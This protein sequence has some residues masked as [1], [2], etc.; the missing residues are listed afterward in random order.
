MQT[1]TL[2]GAGAG[3]ATL[4]LGESAPGGRFVFW[5]HLTSLLTTSGTLTPRHLAGPAGAS[6]IP[7]SEVIGGPVVAFNLAANTEGGCEFVALAR[8][9]SIT[10]A[11]AAANSGRVVEIEAVRIER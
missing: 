6:D 7:F 5:Y 3:V 2:D 8:N 11:S 10:V 4:D 9:L 1:I